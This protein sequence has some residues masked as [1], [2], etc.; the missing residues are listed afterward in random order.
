MLDLCI[1]SALHAHT[2]TDAHTQRRRGL[3]ASGVSGSELYTPS[4]LLKL[5]CLRGRGWLQLQLG[6]VQDICLMY[7][8]SCVQKG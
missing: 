7:A 8:M 2:P 6:L 4:L 3:A 1:E 5:C